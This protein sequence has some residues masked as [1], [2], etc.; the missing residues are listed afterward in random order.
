MNKLTALIEAER[1]KEVINYNPDTGEFVWIKPR[2]PGMPVG[3]AAGTLKNSD[4]YLNVK[5]DNRLYRGHRLAWLYVYGV[6]PAGQ[7]DHINGVR[8]DNRIANLRDVSSKENTHNQRTAH[9]GSKS[10]VLGVTVKPN[11]KFVADIRHNGKKKHL[12]YFSTAEDAHAA[13]VKAKREFHEGA[14][15]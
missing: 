14:T 7:I 10:G 11:G 13:Y 2:R 5:I 3:N 4:G 12:G 8:A 1:L 6:W 9:R 15:L